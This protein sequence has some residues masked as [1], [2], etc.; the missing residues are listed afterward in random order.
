MTGSASRSRPSRCHSCF[1][2]IVIG[3]AGIR[4]SNVFHRM[5]IRASGCGGN[6]ALKLASKA[7]RP[8]SRL[9][10]RDSRKGKATGRQWRPGNN[11]GIAALRTPEASNRDHL[12]FTHAA[13][14]CHQHGLPTRSHSQVSQQS[15]CYDTELKILTLPACKKVG[16]QVS[17]SPIHQPWG[18][19][20]CR[21]SAPS[22]KPAAQGR[23]LSAL[24]MHAVSLPGR[25]AR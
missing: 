7:V 6:A 4:L 11:A 23:R 20:F 8:W 10:G 14:P 2:S 22:R 3:V 25:V 13:K 5:R 1:N 16:V 15:R 21:Y 9:G 17:K 12:M 24:S 18:R 19:I